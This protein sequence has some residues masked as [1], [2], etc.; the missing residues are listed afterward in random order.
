MAA[1]FCK[2]ISCESHDQIFRQFSANCNFVKSS[3]Q[4]TTTNEHFDLEPYIFGLLSLTSILSS[5]NYLQRTPSKCTHLLFIEASLPVRAYAITLSVKTALDRHVRDEV[6]EKF[7]ASPS[8]L[9]QSL[10]LNDLGSFIYHL[11]T[12]FP[13][14]RTASLS[15]QR[16]SNLAPLSP[17]SHTGGIISSIST[18]TP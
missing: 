11:V 13:S 17:A 8:V 5:N 12:I 1:C 18:I 9:V 16:P 3:S 14:S 10:T 6:L 15:S 2:T 4:D 7:E